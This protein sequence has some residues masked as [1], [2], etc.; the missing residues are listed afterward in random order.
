M[1]TTFYFLFVFVVVFNS[2]PSIAQETQKPYVVSPLI[3]D[4][5]LLEERDHYH[6]FPSIKN[7]Q[8]AVFYLNPDSTLNAKVVYLKNLYPQDTIINIYRNLKSLIIHLNATENPVS[9]NPIEN[10]DYSGNEVNVV[11]NNGSEVSGNLLSASSS[12][13]IIYSLGC[14]QDEIN[15]NCAALVKPGDLEKLTVKSDFNLGSIFYPIVT[16]LAAMMIYKS[17]RTN[18]EESLEN[19]GDNFFTAFAVGLGGAL[20]GVGLSYAIPIKTSSEK[21]YPLPLN[22]DEIE[23][24]SKIAR[25]KDFEPYYQLNSK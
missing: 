17:I 4:T 7:F 23:G 11:Y 15:V 2:F 5:L 3:G 21:V 6:L 20:V 16:G 10:K 14:D 9:V 25:Y 24:L 12:S 8:W 22:E 19:M 18:Q 1:K 13:L